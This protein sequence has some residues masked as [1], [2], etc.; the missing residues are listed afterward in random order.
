MRL[1]LAPHDRGG[2]GIDVEDVLHFVIHVIHLLDAAGIHGGLERTVA[3]GEQDDALARGAAG[4]RAGHGIV[5]GERGGSLVIHDDSGY[6]DGAG[7]GGA[8]RRGTSGEKSGSGKSG[9]EHQCFHVI[10]PFSIEQ[11]VR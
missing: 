10:F 2:F 1:L 5:D 7:G 11:L 4:L 6:S 3:R 9:A 8:A